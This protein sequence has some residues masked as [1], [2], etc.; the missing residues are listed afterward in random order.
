MSIERELIDELLS[1]T[2]FLEEEYVFA[3][4]E[5]YPPFLEGT[6]RKSYWYL[7]SLKQLA[8]DDNN[9]D[10]VIDLSRSLLESL[11][12][13]MYVQE[14]GKERKAKKFLMYA[15]IE[16]WGDGEYAIEANFELPPEAIKQRRQEF[17]EVK[18]DYLRPTKREIALKGA[19]HAIWEFEKIVGSLTE[20]Q[21]KQFVEAMIQ[22]KSDEEI[23]NKSWDGTD[24]ET[25][26][27]ELN[28]KGKFPGTLKQSLERI[29]VYGN[30]KNHLSSNDINMLLDNAARNKKNRGYHLSIGLY[31]SLLSYIM[32]M[33]ELAVLRKDER[34][35]NKLEEAKEKLLSAAEKELM[36]TNKS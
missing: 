27:D 26:I 17:D 33:T 31:M 29:Y 2:K 32:I 21:K 7:Y 28:K 12:V 16:T 20:D 30:R 19:S 23:I 3:G 25:M 8:D 22:G 11:I 18:G 9:G 6:A 5:A 4:K 13:V 10:A 24:L 35:K 1:L 36:P 14:F 15:P 34:L